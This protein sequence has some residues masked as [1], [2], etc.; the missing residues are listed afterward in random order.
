MGFNKINGLVL[1]GK[2]TG[3][4]VYYHQIQ[5]FPVNFP[6]IQFYDWGQQEV[7]HLFLW[8]IFHRLSIDYP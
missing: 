8:T 4:Y 7:N 5:G 3:N 1:L 6:I 2:F